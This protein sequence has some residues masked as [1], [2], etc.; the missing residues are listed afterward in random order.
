MMVETRC[1]VAGVG[2]GAIVLAGV[3]QGQSGG[4][5]ASP[6]SGPAPLSVALSY[7]HRA[8]NSAWILDIDFGDA[9]A[10]TMRSPCGTTQ[11]T[12]NCAPGGVWTAT[13]RYALP[14]TYVAT[15]TRG[16]LPLC[17][18]CRP[19]VLATVTVTVNR[20]AGQ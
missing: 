18:T 17:A 13:H 6:V 5:A 12:Q 15:L 10:A 11:G 7:P 14:G 2:L 4:L 19:P 3:T 9:S 20:A 16:G 8:E 1:A